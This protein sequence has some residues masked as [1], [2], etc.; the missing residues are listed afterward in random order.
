MIVL[1][2]LLLFVAAALCLLPP[3]LPRLPLRSSRTLTPALQHLDPSSP[4]HSVRPA[5]TITLLIVA[6]QHS[7]FFPQLSH[8]FSPT[9]TLPPSS[10][11]PSLQPPHTYPPALPPQL[12]H[13]FRPA[14]QLPHSY[15]LAL[16]FTRC[17]PL[18]QKSCSL[19]RCSTRPPPPSSPKPLHKPSHTFHAAAPHPPCSSP[20]HIPQPSRSLGAPGC[21]E[22]L[23]V[24]DGEWHKRAITG[25]STIAGGG[26]HHLPGA[27]EIARKGSVR[28]CGHV[29]RG[30]SVVSMPAHTARRCGRC[31]VNMSVHTAQLCRRC[32]IVLGMGAWSSCAIMLG[33][34]SPGTHGC[35]SAHTHD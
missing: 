14:P 13:T 4:V 33:C 35:G 25:G 5:A 27:R 32:I 11:T 6:M 31:V 21:A 2:D 23:L 19:W 8:A 18:Q 7:P 26:V 29:C 30:L 17:A 22:P 28:K 3:A 15:P 9:P 34:H 10:P 20:T 16:P 12:L 24:V 1:E